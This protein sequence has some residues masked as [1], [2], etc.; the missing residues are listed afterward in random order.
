MCWK[1]KYIRYSNAICKFTV[2]FYSREAKKHTQRDTEREKQRERD[3]HRV[4]ETE[5]ATI[6]WFIF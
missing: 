5:K 4:I 6:L 1:C 3:T 2:F